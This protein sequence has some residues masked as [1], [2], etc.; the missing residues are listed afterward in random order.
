[1]TKIVVVSALNTRTY[2]KMAKVELIPY[3]I[4]SPKNRFSGVQ[5]NISQPLWPALQGHSFL[6]CLTMDKSSLNLKS[7]N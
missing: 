6:Y 4:N 1:M 3:L 2:D 5:T 7:W